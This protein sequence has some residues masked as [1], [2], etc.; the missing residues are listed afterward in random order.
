MF[1]AAAKSE[2]NL[3]FHHKTSHARRYL[4]MNIHLNNVAQLVNSKEPVNA[5]DVVSM[6]PNTILQAYQCKG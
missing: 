1:L 5:K 4:A 2:S 3:A 6:V